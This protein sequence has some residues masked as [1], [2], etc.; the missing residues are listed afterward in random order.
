M[1]LPHC[2]YALLFVCLL[3][4]NSKSKQT[5]EATETSLPVINLS[6]NISKVEGLP[7]SD[8]ASGVEKVILEVTDKSLIGKIQKVEI[9]AHDIWI[10]TF[11]NILRFSREGK[12]LN[13][14]GRKGQG[15][16]EYNNFSN[17]FIDEDNADIYIIPS[18]GGGLLVYEYD[19]RFKHKIS[20]WRTLEDILNM[21][22]EKFLFLNGYCF[23]EQS[24]A[25]MYDIPT[26]SLWTIGLFDKDFK[27]AKRFKNPGMTGHESEIIKN[28]GSNFEIVNYWQQPSSTITA[29]GNETTLKYCDTDTIYRFDKTQELFLPQYAIHTNEPK[30][31][32]GATHQW[33]KEREA[34]NYFTIGRYYPTKDYIYL[35]GYKGDEIY[36][37]CYNKNNGSVRLTK[38]T[39]QIEER[40]LPW[41]SSPHRRIKVDF[42]LENDL[43]GGNKFTIDYTSS[44]K[45]W[46]D[47]VEPE[48]EDANP[49]LMIATLK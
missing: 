34:F 11:E 45:Y 24:G 4:C 42:M 38:E 22:S 7:L 33:I 8:A 23:L 17:Y 40:R 36:N 13:S 27:I 47:V 49:H 26:D 44:G 48:D 16:G 28:K 12:F 20:A 37:Y 41:F 31:D 46:V 9:T 2:I 32:Y 39:T 14:V 10:T 18:N 21:N 6:E 43:Q 30:G 15:P 25:V 5:N 29:Y 1:K 3:S 19:G 35:V